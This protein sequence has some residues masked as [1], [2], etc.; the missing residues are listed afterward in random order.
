MRS[1]TSTSSFF[2]SVLFLTSM[3]SIFGAAWC[4]QAQ[5]ITW[6]ILPFPE[7]S[8]WPGPK[9]SPSVT[10]GNQVIFQGQPVRS[11]QIFTPPVTF[12]YDVLLQSRSSDASDGAFW[13]FIIPPGED[14]DLNITS[15]FL[16]QLSYNLFAGTSFVDIES[17]PPSTVVVPPVTTINVTTGMTYHCVLAVAANGQM[18]WTINGQTITSN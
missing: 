16:P 4:A 13:M 8:D 17:G 2:K 6:Q 1:A 18:T 5:S 14:P 7:N 11:A 9:G 3:L 15:Y 12:S 10:N